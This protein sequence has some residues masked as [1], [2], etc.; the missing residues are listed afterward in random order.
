MLILVNSYATK[1][2]RLYSCAGL[3]IRLQP[4]AI[5]SCYVHSGGILTPAKHAATVI[6]AAVLSVFLN[7]ASGMLV[8]LSTRLWQ[9]MQPEAA[10]AG[11]RESL[12]SR[13][14]GWHAA[15]M[16]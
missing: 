14:W 15:R 4:S 9:Q 10:T 7:L 6:L 13:G 11:C 5:R 3:I 12:G 8:E 1:H 2:T 16:A